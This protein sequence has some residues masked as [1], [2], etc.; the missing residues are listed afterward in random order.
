MSSE[1]SNSSPV[2]TPVAIA[3]DGQRAICITF[4]DDKQVRWTAEQLRK[5]CPCA[6]CREKHRAEAS[7]K[8]KAKDSGKPQLLPVLSMAEARPLTVQAME[9]VG[10]YGYSISF[11]DGHSSGIFLFDVLYDGAAS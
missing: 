7:D 2:H 5:H 1:F 3:R 9:P 11:S 4:D 8:E 6:T 10:Q